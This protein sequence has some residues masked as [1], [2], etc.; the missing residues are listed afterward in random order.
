MTTLDKAISTSS[1][2]GLSS[3]TDTGS[4]S[5]FYVQKRVLG[6]DPGTANFAWCGLG[7]GDLVYGCQDVSP[8]YASKDAMTRDIVPIIQSKIDSFKPDIVVVENQM[9]Q[10]M[11]S[12]ATMVRTASH[13][14]GIQFKTI[15]P[16]SVKARFKLAKSSNKLSQPKRHNFNKIQ[17]LNYINSNVSINGQKLK[18]TNHNCADALMLCLYTLSENS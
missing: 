1:D 3:S 15:H 13:M 18:L 4:S 12:I 16:N 14:R 6:F 7:D 17:A 2:S 10:R 8:T 9:R 11:D 5:R